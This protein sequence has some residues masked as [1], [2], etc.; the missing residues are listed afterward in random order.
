MPSANGSA[1]PLASQPGD[2]AVVLCQAL[3]VGDQEST[4]VC[5]G[6]Q[7]AG[8]LHPDCGTAAAMKYEHQRHRA[9]GGI[10]ARDVQPV[11]SVTGAICLRRRDR[12][13][14][15][16]RGARPDARPPPAAHRGDRPVDQAVRTRLRRSG[17]EPTRLDGR[18]AIDVARR[19]AG[20]DHHAAD[21]KTTATGHA[22]LT[23]PRSP[24]PHSI[25]RPTSGIK[26]RSPQ[27]G[28]LR[29]SQATSGRQ[30][31]APD[32]SATEEPCRR[33]GRTGPGR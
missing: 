1:G 13:R 9:G 15:L 16:R 33:P 29:A 21:R 5:L 20:G 4:P 32:V 22:S 23:F 24:M 8:A 26:R 31:I 7:A 11:T 10:A 19:G 30:P 18:G 3:R 6:G 17:G 27:T 25:A 28:D 14:Q 12:H 2:A